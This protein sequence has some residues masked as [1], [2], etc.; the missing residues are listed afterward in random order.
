[1]GVEPRTGAPIVQQTMQVVESFLIRELST[2][3]IS[4]WVGE[5]AFRREPAG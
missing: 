1:M 2:G 4:E 5:D 3:A